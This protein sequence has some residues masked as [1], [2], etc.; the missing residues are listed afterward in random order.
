MKV[1]QAYT[2]WAETYDSD[3]NLTRDLD[4]QITRKTLG[5][6]RFDSVVEIGCGTGKNTRLLAEIASTVVA[7][8]FSEAM[9]AR[10]REKSRFDNVTFKLADINQP[11]PCDDKSADLICCNLVLEH[12]AN[13]SFAFAE[14][15]RVLVPHG[16][17]FIS[18]LHPF[19]QYQGVQARFSRN[20]ETTLIPAFVHHMTNFLDAASANKL[21]LV[22]LNEWWH[23]EDE[24]KPPRLISLM[25]QA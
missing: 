13:L 15:A 7:L 5:E 19:R 1:Q 22:R 11:W 9:I 14:A 3:R 4:Q 16:Q 6:L 8:D 18:E 17:F 25:F 24:G 2:D 21:S 23:E 10:A 20:E 12:V